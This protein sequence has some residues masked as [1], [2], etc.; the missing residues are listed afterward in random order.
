M[1]DSDSSNGTVSSISCK[2]IDNLSDP[3]KKLS[4]SDSD[5]DV[6]EI[7][8]KYEMFPLET[9]KTPT[10]NKKIGRTKERSSISSNEINF[11]ESDHDSLGTRVRKKLAKKAK[12][13]STPKTKKK[14]NEEPKT[15]LKNK[16]VPKAK[17]E[18]KR[19]KS[20][21]N[22]KEVKTSSKNFEQKCSFLKS[23]S[24]KSI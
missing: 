6:E 11:S 22:K 20:D 2:S 7:N 9:K 21:K 23:L 15:K 17:T 3:C 14:V 8:K 10:I 5:S 12:D 4:F 24:G 1:C 18:N 13:L 19:N 16:L